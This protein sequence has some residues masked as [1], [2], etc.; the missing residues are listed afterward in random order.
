MKSLAAPQ[1]FHIIVRMASRP[2]EKVKG[3][4]FLGTWVV[5]AGLLAPVLASPAGFDI[6]PFARRCCVADTHAL[7]VAFDYE[8]ARRAPD[9]AGLSGITDSK[10]PALLRRGPRFA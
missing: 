3:L 1:P 6:A 7:Q 4:W 2:V 5:A 9:P 8:Q 10:P